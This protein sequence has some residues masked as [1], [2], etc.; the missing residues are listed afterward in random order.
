MLAVCPACGGAG[1]RPHRTE[2]AVQEG[3][4]VYRLKLRVCGEC[5][6]TGERPEKFRTIMQED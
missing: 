2:V 3:R 1:T 6:G 4:R 5:R